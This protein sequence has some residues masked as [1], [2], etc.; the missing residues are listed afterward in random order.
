M[1]TVTQSRTQDELIKLLAQRRAEEGNTAKSKPDLLRLVVEEVNSDEIGILGKLTPGQIL[2]EIQQLN[3]PSINSFTARQE[4]AQT[5][6][7]QVNKPGDLT[8]AQRLSEI[9]GL[10]GSG[11]EPESLNILMGGMTK[12][13]VRF[14]TNQKSA[15]TKI[16]NDIGTSES[17]LHCS[18]KAGKLFNEILNTCF[19]HKLP[20]VFKNAKPGQI[21]KL[22][23]EVTKSC[24]DVFD[25]SNRLHEL[26]YV[27]D[28]KTKNPKKYINAARD[29]TNKVIES[30]IPEI[31]EPYMSSDLA[32]YVDAVINPSISTVPDPCDPKLTFEISKVETEVKPSCD[33]AE[34]L[35]SHIIDAIFNEGSPIATAPILPETSKQPWYT[36][37]W[38]SILTKVGLRKIPIETSLPQ[39]AIDTI[40]TQ[41]NPVAETITSNPIELDVTSFPSSQSSSRKNDEPSP[42]LSFIVGGVATLGGLLWGKFSGFSWKNILTSV[43]GLF[44]LG[45]G[46]FESFSTKK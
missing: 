24:G 29:I 21:E 27:R 16:L 2:E 44:A 33:T 23:S 26:L 22:R 37:A 35:P 36:R 39:N 5:N 3:K 7:K 46:A 19:E 15:I 14:N 43:F 28:V 9:F 32:T 4:I 41:G 34:Q 11:I 12:L 45:S 31:P 18:G 42:I 17:I 13:F 8:N 6:I 30:R 20:K 38:N 10:S 40:F 1:T 25:L